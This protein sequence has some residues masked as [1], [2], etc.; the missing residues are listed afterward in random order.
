MQEDRPVSHYVK[1]KSVSEMAS[2]WSEQDWWKKMPCPLHPSWKLGD[3]SEL[4]LRKLKQNVDTDDNGLMVVELAIYRAFLEFPRGTFFNQGRANPTEALAYL[5]GAEEHVKAKFQGNIDAVIGYGIIINT[6]RLWIRMD[7]STESVLRDLVTRK[8]GYPNHESYIQ[9]V[10]AYILSRL[11]PRWRNSALVLY[12]SALKRFPQNCEWLF[13]KALMIGREARQLG[14]DN[15]FKDKTVR[16]K[17]QKEK[18]IL[19][20]VLVIDPDFHQARAFYGQVLFSLGENGAGVEISRALKEEPQNRS[21]A[22]VAVRYHRRNGT[23]SWAEIVLNRLLET[24]NTAETNFQLGILYNSKARNVHISERFSLWRKA[25]EYFDRG[26]ELDMC[27]YPCYTRR[28]EMNA[29]L[30]ERRKAHGLF[31][32][33]F[34]YIYKDKP[35]LATHEMH[36]ISIALEM[37]LPKHMQVFTVE[38]VIKL[39]HRYV[40]LAT[41][42]GLT[43]VDD[44]ADN[45]PVK[46]KIDKYLKKLKNTISDESEKDSVRDMATLKLGD[47]H[48]RLGQ[49]GDAERLYMEKYLQGGE[50]NLDIMWGLAKCYFNQGLHDK[51]TAMARKLERVEQHQFDVNELYADV[52]LSI[53]KSKLACETGFCVDDIHCR[54]DII[55]HLEQ[56]IE[57]GSLEACYFFLTKVANL[58]E[59]YFSLKGR[60]SEILAKIRLVCENI[61]PNIHT[62]FKVTLCDGS[63]IIH[64]EMA[65]R[66]EIREKVNKLLKYDAFISENACSSEV[67]NEYKQ[68]ELLR[69]ARLDFECE[70]LKRKEGE[71]WNGACKE[72]LTEVLQIARVVLDHVVHIYQ[73]LVLEQ[74]PGRSIFAIHFDWDRARVDTKLAEEKLKKSI[75]T[76]FPGYNMPE[77]TF[78]IILEVQPMYDRNKLWLAALGSFNSALKHKTYVGEEIFD[79]ELKKAEWIRLK[80][81][82]I[83]RKSCPEVERLVLYFLA[84]FN[85]LK[86]DNDSQHP[87]SQ[88]N[89]EAESE[90]NE[91][92]EKEGIRNRIDSGKKN[93]K[94]RERKME[95]KE[96]EKS[97]EKGKKPERNKTK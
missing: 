88:N 62:Y 51:S 46:G 61:I 17:F 92:E 12:D 6:F 13:G 50:D 87:M 68:L 63:N 30:G 74:P 41:D 55:E 82:D 67:I 90:C 53:A 48:L 71:H 14:F 29:R 24:C 54:P 44:R 86:L 76:L 59:Q 45:I 89:G 32:E 65:K 3:I 66:N 22:M 34:E 4:D 39:C 36:T 84:M 16:D 79:L 8:D 18:Q 58:H 94:E 11:G 69:H 2:P 21:I 93:G 47:A 95:G 64:N 1:K 60:V 96:R 56:A 38:E 10:K 20:R 57:K 70:L 52:H 73:T 23:F 81:E 31:Q 9:V 85:T 27:H 28:A 91:S 35:Q 43:T 75:S 78:R 40:T 33:L 5:G 26:I 80:S 72:K 25:L 49:F 15:S 97:I 19:K 7:G 37:G 77:S 42:E 83:V